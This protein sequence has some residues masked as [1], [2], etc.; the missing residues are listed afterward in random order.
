MCFRP[1]SAAKI[2]IKC[3]KCGTTAKDEDT[4]CA[5]CGTDLPKPPKSA[6]GGP[7]VPA[8]P[9]MGGGPKVPPMPKTP[10]KA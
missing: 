2:E 7:G 10:G 5:K 8:P 3:P 1:S 6:G 4:A 9:G